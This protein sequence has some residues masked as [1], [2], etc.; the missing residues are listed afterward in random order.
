MTI[1]KAPIKNNDHIIYIFSSSF[2]INQFKRTY[3][4]FSNEYIDNNAFGKDIIEGVGV[5]EGEGL[6]FTLTPHLPHPRA[7]K[8]QG[9]E[10]I[11]KMFKFQKISLFFRRFGHPFR[12]NYS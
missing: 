3:K 4:V 1:Q 5:G 7:K 8:V 6:L 9:S 12:I 10:K 2:N 11:R